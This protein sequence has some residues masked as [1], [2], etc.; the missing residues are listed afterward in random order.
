MK[1]ALRALSA[2]VTVSLLAALAACSNSS[3]AES[4]GKQGYTLRIGTTS[5]TGTPAGN[6]GWGDKQGILKD[7]LAAAGVTK[8]KYSYF[9]SGK[10]IVSALLSGAVDVAAVGDNPSVTAKGNGADVT[11]LSMDSINGDGYLVGAKGGPTTIN[12]LVG[13]TVTA[14]QGTQRDRTARQLISLA[15]LSSKIT[16]SDLGTPES[17]AGLKSGKIAAAAV[18][19]ATA[20]QLHQQ[21]F[22]IIDQLSRHNGLGGVGNDIALTRFTKAHPTFEKA[23]QDAITGINSDILT[24]YDDYTSWVGQTDGLSAAIERQANPR[25]TFNTEPYPAAGVTELQST[26]DFLVKQGTIK[27]PFKVA[28]W[29][30]QSSADAS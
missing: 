2:L 27:T 5:V 21:G 25:N 30:S 11:L 22:P 28:G 4:A 20:I 15:G 17:V 29:V 18:D 9:Q 24:H 7:K 8:I 10:D 1:K 3:A 6:I 14:P 23:W 19:G 26:V 12:G 13:K 16:V